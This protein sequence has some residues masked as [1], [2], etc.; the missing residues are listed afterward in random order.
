MGKMTNRKRGFI[1]GF[2]FAVALLIEKYGE[3]IY[4]EA[5][6]REGDL[7]LKDCREADV[8]GYEMS[9]LRPILKKMEDK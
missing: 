3:S 2:A 5:L 1:Q 8:V 6:I 4:T 7:T 9:I